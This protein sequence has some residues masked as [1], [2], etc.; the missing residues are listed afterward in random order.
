MELQVRSLK[1][2]TQM[3][4]VFKSIKRGMEEAIAHSKDDKAKV[5]LFM[6]D[7]VNVNEVQEESHSQAD[8][9]GGVK[10]FT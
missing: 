9:N 4:E 2:I 6:P 3:G 7:K 5:R 10:A 8:K 1:E